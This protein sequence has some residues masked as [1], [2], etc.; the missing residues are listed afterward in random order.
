MREDLRNW[1]AFFSS[2]S[3]PDGCTFDAQRPEEAAKPGPGRP[4]VKRD[5]CRL[6]LKGL[7]G[8]GPMPVREV[9]SQGADR[10]FDAKSLYAAAKALGVE[11][12]LVDNKKWWKLPSDS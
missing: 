10:G 7:L 4:A 8:V 11:E 3:T 9:R 2:L 12:F 1:R 5:M 6:W